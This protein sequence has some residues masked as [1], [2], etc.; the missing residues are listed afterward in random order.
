MPNNTERIAMNHEVARKILDLA[1]WAP[2]GDN[3]QPWR[4]EIVNDRHIVVYGFDTRDHC[5]YDLRGHGSQISLGALLE[6]ITI[7]ASAHHF[8]TSIVRRSN[9]L[10]CSTTFDV[11]LLQGAEV[12]PL[13]PY[14]RERCVQRRPLQARRLSSGEKRALEESLQSEYKVLWFDG[15][16]GK[17]SFAKLLYFNAGLRLTLPEA[18]E[19]HRNAIEWD[20]SF[21][22]TGIPDKALG[23]SIL[24]LKAM[25][26]VM[27]SWSRVHV[28]NRYFGGTILPRIEMDL[29]PA[30]ACGA[31]F[32]LVRNKEPQSVDDY[33]EVGKN[34][35]RF[36][37]EATK[38]GLQVQ[39]QMT[40]LVFS[41]Y[42]RR[43]IEFTTVS[44]MSEKAQVISSCL[45]RLLGAERTTNAVF[46]G[47]IGAGRRAVHRSVRK[48]L[49]ELLV[50]GQSVI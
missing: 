4:F 19:T 8:R 29:I 28:M 25:R 26:W 15:L 34:V 21:S 5:I 24:T 2:S 11:Y 6:N 38:I 1:R 31:H 39:P 41:S 37:L 49:Q 18:Y 47:R 17:V 16:G 40:P 13:V 44:A 35:Q 42:L 48:A 14:V 12:D 3:S 23:A 7:A 43:G 22:E 50:P 9:P 33:V 36:W 30:F 27:K 45:E 20:T 46:M 32:V 10:Q